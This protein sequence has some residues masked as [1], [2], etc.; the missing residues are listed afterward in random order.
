MPIHLQ[1]KLQC[2]ALGRVAQGVDEVRLRI[3]KQ[4]FTFND[5]LRQPARNCERNC[6]WYHDL[7]APGFDVSSHVSMLGELFVSIESNAEVDLCN[8]G[9][10]VH[11]LLH[12]D[13]TLG[14]TASNSVVVE[15]TWNA[16]A[17]R[18]DLSIPLGMSAVDKLSVAFPLR[19]PPVQHSGSQMLVLVRT[20]Q[21]TSYGPTRAKGSVLH[22]SRQA[23]INHFSIGES[24]PTQGA[25]NVMELEIG[26]NGQI[27]ASPEGV[28]ITISG[29]LNFASPSTGSLRLQPCQ[30]CSYVP[31][32]PDSPAES[33]DLAQYIQ[34]PDAT[35]ARWDQATGR[36]SFYL[37][38]PGPTYLIVE[39]KLK[40]RVH[41]GNRD[42]ASTGSLPII[43]LT[44]SLVVGT[45]SNLPAK[46]SSSR[47]L[48]GQVV[49][50]PLMAH[51][52]YFPSTGYSHPKIVMK[53]TMNYD[54]MHGDVV[55]MIAPRLTVCPTFCYEG[56]C[57]RQE[58]A[59]AV[60]PLSFYVQL[61]NANMSGAGDGTDFMSA[62]W[63]ELEKRLEFHLSGG[64][65]LC[66]G[67][68]AFVS[69][70]WDRCAN[71]NILLPH[72]AECSRFQV[73]PDDVPVSG[74]S[75]VETAIAGCV[76]STGCVNFQTS[77]IS[78][79]RVDTKIGFYWGQPVY[80][81]VN[82]SA[83]EA[84][85]ERET[86]V[87]RSHFSAQL[88][89]GSIF[90]LGGLTTCAVDAASEARVSDD[91]LIWRSTGKGLPW[92]R[93]DFSTVSFRGYMWAIG[94]SRLVND[95]KSKYLSV[96]HD[97]WR[98][99]DATQW[100]L[101][102]SA[103]AWE[104]RSFHASL[105]FQDKIW[106]IA[107]RNQTE[108]S[109]C[110][111]W[112]TRDGRA[113]RLVSSCAPFQP[114]FG[115]VATVFASKMWVYGGENEASDVWWSMNGQNWTAATM[116]AAWGRRRLP[117]GL[118]FDGRLWLG[119][120]FVNNA[121]TKTKTALRDLWYSTDGIT[122]EVANLVPRITAGEGRQ[123]LVFQNR[124]FL[125]MVVF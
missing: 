23:S 60:S 18:V 34:S 35:T 108:S 76:N 4:Q 115:H 112:S 11:G 81:I 9:N 86:A 2:N 50:N 62:T 73:L 37:R 69:L 31:S 30:D 79:S 88:H 85:T 53:L 116:S 97:V 20:P 61:T 98:S 12:L 58:K 40:A 74:E 80:E 3:G 94:G 121:K 111:V 7:L 89:N 87:G 59:C 83:F 46:D 1:A 70:A 96:M 77:S 99:T 41:L 16:L 47:V 118:S 57:T 101:V 19:N 72:A 102:A 49:A 107:G 103:A 26:F 93:L 78:N 92:P 8:Q 75:S 25:L 38:A 109:L 67:Q 43:T 55:T 32:D 45:S 22:A 105:V 66:K 14:P 42:K 124:S 56:R 117:I 5:H 28:W 13:W 91:G 122:W 39:S 51:I 64:R 33:T 100:E 24:T 6:S 123:L 15:A 110:D 27:G 90:A 65:A 10:M 113:W 84:C 48:T 125:L 17:G 68:V 36:L 119:A 54:V 29:L 71:S 120:G 106:I 82:H 95:G 63:Y 114:R 21:G 44:G 52:D 104:A